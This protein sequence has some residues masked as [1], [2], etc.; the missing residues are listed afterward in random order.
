M[1]VI[2]TCGN[3]LVTTSHHTV[4][5]CQSYGGQEVKANDAIGFRIVSRSASTGLL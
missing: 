4:I 3:K 1:V 2:G 5:T